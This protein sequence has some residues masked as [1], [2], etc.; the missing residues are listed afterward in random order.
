MTGNGVACEEVECLKTCLSISN[1]LQQ[2]A[3]GNNG[4]YGGGGYYG[5]NSYGNSYGGNSYGNGGGGGGGYDSMM[6]N[7]CNEGGDGYNSYGYGYRG[8]GGYYDGM[9]G[10]MG[11]NMGEQDPE[12]QCMIQ[13]NKCVAPDR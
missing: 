8:L 3:F 6:N 12:G 9:G 7:Q 2:L 1:S 10:D 13:N 4:D 5:G 11:G